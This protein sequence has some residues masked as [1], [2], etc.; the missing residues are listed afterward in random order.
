MEGGLSTRA[1]VQILNLITHVLKEHLGGQRAVVNLQPTCKSSN[2][3]LT[4]KR[5]GG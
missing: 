4:P 3:V 2:N 1:A 5:Y